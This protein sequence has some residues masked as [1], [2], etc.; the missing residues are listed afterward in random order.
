[1]CVVVL[2]VSVLPFGGLATCPGCRMDGWMELKV[3]VGSCTF[4][5]SHF[6]FCLN[7]LRTEKNK[8]LFIYAHFVACMYNKLKHFLTSI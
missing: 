8:H 3:A 6:N 5:C 2:C 1:M 4:V 7:V